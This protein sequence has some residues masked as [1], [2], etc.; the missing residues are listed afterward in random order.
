MADWPYSTARWQKLR[1]AKLRANPLCEVC[2]AAGKI[3]LAHAVDHVVA[4]RN[5]GDPFP[6]LE[7]L[8]SL[9][10]AHH[11]EKTATDL[12]GGEHV[13]K[14]CD[15]DGNPIDPAH[16]FNGGGNHHGKSRA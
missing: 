10:Q 16:P 6:M 3:V 4:I 5:G 1:R 12:A 7:G 11:N 9:C 15:A 2:E 14:G 8:R 13:F